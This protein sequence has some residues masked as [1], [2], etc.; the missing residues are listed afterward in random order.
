MTDGG[1]EEGGEEGGEED[2]EEEVAFASGLRGGETSP[3]PLFSPASRSAHA[4]RITLWERGSRM[5]AKKAAKKKTAKKAA[6]KK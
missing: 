6:K 3:S 5:P 1:Q 4:V 2:G